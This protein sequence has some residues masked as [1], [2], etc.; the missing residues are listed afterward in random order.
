MGWP[1][2]VVVREDHRAALLAQRPGRGMP[3]TD[4]DHTRVLVA[5]DRAA[6]RIAGAILVNEERQEIGGWLA[7]AYR[8]RGLGRELFQ[9]AAA[10]VH[11]HLGIATVRAGT[12]VA[13]TACVG[14]LTSAGFVA[15]EGPTDH[16]LPDGRVTQA[17]WFRHD[18]DQPTTCR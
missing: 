7:P 5:I 11:H 18:T 9:G 12:D 10:L 16:R 14:A 3:W 15:T 4:R 17:Q 8:A 1:P 2:E 13:N 6:D